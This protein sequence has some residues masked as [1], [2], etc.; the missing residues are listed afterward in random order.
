M[1]S[2][3]RIP[4]RA[5]LIAAL[6][7]AGIT[8]GTA[9]AHDWTPLDEGTLSLSSRYVNAGFLPHRDFTYP[10]TGGLAFL[11]A[12]TAR[13]F[14]DTML[15]ARWV[16]FAVFL[17][18]LCGTWGIARRLCT[19]PVAAIVVIL[20]AFWSLLMYPAAQPT[21]YLLFLMTGAVAAL[22]R[23]D[24]RNE[25]RWVVV[26]GLLCGL[27]IVLKQTGLYLLV[28][29]GLGV[30]AIRQSKQSA[31][32]GA[33]ANPVVL[34]LLTIGFAV[35]ALLVARKGVLTGDALIVAVPIAAVLATLLLRE[36]RAGSGPASELIAAWSRLLA[37]A[38]VFP[39]LLLS[40]YAARGG[41]GAAVD[42]LLRESVRTFGR[43]ETDMKPL[44]IVLAHG[45]PVAIVAVILLRLKPSRL[46]L[47]LSVA[48]AGVAFALAWM[49]DPGYRAVWHFTTLIIPAAAL[50]VAWY[51]R[52]RDPG[53]PVPSSILL[54]AAA[55]ALQGLNQFP[56]GAANYFGYVAPLAFLLVAMM[57]SWRGA[58]RRLVFVAAL[59]LA[60][61]FRFHRIGDVGTLAF[62]PVWREATHALP[63]PHAGLFVVEEDSATYARLLEL[64]RANGGPDSVVAGPEL[65]AL[66]VLSGT[67]RLVRQPY[68]LVD[69]EHADSAA[70]AAALDVASTRAVAI[71]DAPI[72][73]PR[74]RPDAREWIAIRYP[75]AERV[76]SIEFRWR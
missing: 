30:L 10:Y 7:V 22:L 36:R 72:F 42:G 76:G 62:G 31:T 50:G 27:G 51:E 6:L 44:G 13:A 56:F 25:A 33:R 32:H 68:L 66:Y 26:A 57:A 41:L 47:G 70:V 5:W 38:A 15:G 45:L 69:D 64:V 61:A 60:Y 34:A 23:W 35:P 17:L 18:W 37:G 3:T 1:S 28:A 71:Q 40:V 2:V 16:L 19:P 21:W 43:I 63:G 73:L 12:L 29:A 54:V 8:V 39:A 55:M 46:Q 9:L 11:G 48:A 59:P 49:S 4:E 58:E 65:A 20:A 52:R 24:E 53:H 74:L 75:N 67:T 14:G